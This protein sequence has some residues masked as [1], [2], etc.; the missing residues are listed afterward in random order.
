MKVR[1]LFFGG[2]RDRLGK[3]EVLLELASDSTLA[4]VWD[5]V[6]VGKDVP[7]DVLAAINMEY[8]GFEQQVADGDEVAFFPPV[9]GG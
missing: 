4:D 3:P 7:S 9:T 5:Q 8:A 1:V 2:L 6:V